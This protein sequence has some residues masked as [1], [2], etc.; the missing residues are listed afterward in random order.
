MV[1][2]PGSG[3]MAAESIKL[4]L[5]ISKCTTSRRKRGVSHHGLCTCFQPSDLTV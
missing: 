1:A 3:R 5:G 2:E 4:S